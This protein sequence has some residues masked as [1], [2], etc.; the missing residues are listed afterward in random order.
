[1]IGLDANVLLRLVLTDEDE[2]RKR[3]LALLETETSPLR[4]GLIEDIALAETVW[5][6]R[7]HVPND[8]SA[9]A[10][11]IGTLLDLP[12]ARLRDPVVVREALARYRSGGPGFGDHLLAARNTAAGCETTYTF[13]VRAARDD[14]FTLVP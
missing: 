10:A 6:L 13:D 4:P 11:L 1:M 2:Q 5:T 12:Q 14:R 9:V 7:R 3:A 8:P